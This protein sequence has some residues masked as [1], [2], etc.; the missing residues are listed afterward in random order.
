MSRPIPKSL[1]LDQ[2][3]QRRRITV[4]DQLR[5]RWS[6][7]LKSRAKHLPDNELLM[8]K[9]FF[10]HHMSYNNIAKALGR[11]RGS[12]H[13]Q[14]HGVVRRLDSDMADVLCDPS[15]P[16]PEHLVRLGL[17]RFV[18]NEPLKKLAE[19]LGVTRHQ[20]QRQLNQLEGWILRDQAGRRKF[21]RDL[22]RRT[23]E[24]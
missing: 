15:C 18:R 21:V 16:L 23:A 8:L 4:A 6:E 7:K 13:R 12:V 19:E 22:S 5:L 17:R 11:S 9:M 24:R 14:I 10:E 20:M 2:L 3:D 1:H